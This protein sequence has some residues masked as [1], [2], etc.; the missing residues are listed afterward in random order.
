MTDRRQVEMA[1]D[2]RL[3][4]REQFNLAA[5]VV[6]LKYAKL[7]Q[8]L[9][10]EHHAEFDQVRDQL[11]LSRFE[12]PRDQDRVDFLTGELKRLKARPLPTAEIEALDRQRQA[13]IAV[14][15]EVLRDKLAEIDLR[16]RRGTLTDDMRWDESSQRFVPQL[17]PV[18]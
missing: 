5:G 6:N 1:Y 16:V 7:R 4:A 2:L 11:T 12:Q 13:E 3:E 15:D 18:E 9:L 8:S 10:D 17:E 14:F